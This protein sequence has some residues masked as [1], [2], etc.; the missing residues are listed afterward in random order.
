MASLHLPEGVFHPTLPFCTFTTLH[1]RARGLGSDWWASSCLQPLPVEHALLALV[2]KLVR[3]H[4]S[5]WTSEVRGE[6][7]HP[8]IPSPHK[9]IQKAVL[10]CSYCC[11]HPRTYIN[12]QTEAQNN[13]T[14]R[15]DALNTKIDLSRYLHDR[16]ARRV[17]LAA[18]LPAKLRV[19]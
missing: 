12:E 18:V 15:W 1:R 11:P 2:I 5:G 9:A 16:S 17:Q 14:D 13:T 10:A 8:P 4:M 6:C 3:L 7:S 19:C